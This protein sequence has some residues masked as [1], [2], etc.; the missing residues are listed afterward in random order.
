MFGDHLGVRRAIVSLKSLSGFYMVYLHGM[1]MFGIFIPWMNYADFGWF[2]R[3]ISV[4]KVLLTSF[5][6]AYAGFHLRDKIG[7]YIGS[8]RL[9]VSF[10]TDALRLFAVLAALEA[11]RLSMLTLSL[12]HVFDWSA[13]HFIGLS[14]IVTCSLLAIHASLVLPFTALLLLAHAPLERFVLSF[15]T[16]YQLITLEN[17]ELVSWVWVVASV[18]LAACVLSWAMTSLLPERRKRWMATGIGAAVMA[19]GA[20]AFLRPILLSSPR[21]ITNLYNLPG[22]IFFSNTFDDNYWPFF[23][24]YPLFASGYF[25]RSIAFKFELRRWEL[26][27]WIFTLAGVASLLWG[28]VPATPVNPHATFDKTYFMKWHGMA[29]FVAGISLLVLLTYH[30]QRIGFPRWL[31]R[32]TYYSRNLILIYL[33]HGPLIRLVIYLFPL[34]F[35]AQF[36][37]E[38]LFPTML[39]VYP[40]VIV[41]YFVSLVLAHRFDL[42]LDSLKSSR[43]RT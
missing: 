13:L 26:A 41:C 22:A 4:F 25:F 30:G 27:L 20:A 34:D 29:G 21:A 17:R 40:S 7:P 15:A 19:L 12:T 35:V 32:W 38:K 5:L 11:L 6:P 1:T 37:E 8:K 43:I 36:S 3:S 42:A 9:P 16:P 2:I 14:G 31:E 18:L 39:F 23:L 28:L 24:C 10:I 33:L